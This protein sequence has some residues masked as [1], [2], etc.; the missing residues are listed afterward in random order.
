MKKV[1]IF[2]INGEMGSGE[3]C[4]GSCGS[5]EGGPIT[6]ESFVQMFKDKNKDVAEFSIF[7]FKN[8]PQE[9][10]IK[11]LN[12][13]L[14]GSGQKLTITVKNFFFMVSKILPIIAV[15]GKIIS[16]GSCLNIDDLG[17]AI[18]QGT[19]VSCKSGCC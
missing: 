13:A 14:A 1:E 2:V 4:G 17:K 18:I 16:L 9:D 6:P 15:D 19:S 8:K 11:C 10:M 12:A 5:G 3:G 7:D